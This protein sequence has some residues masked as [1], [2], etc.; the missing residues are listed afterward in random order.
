M[1]KEPG[2]AHDQSPTNACLLSFVH[3][4]R[5]FANRRRTEMCTSL[6]RVKE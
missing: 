4:A 2:P 3:Y 1:P 5:G 6:H